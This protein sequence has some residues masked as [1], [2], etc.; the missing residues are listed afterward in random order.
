MDDIFLYIFLS[1]SSLLLAVIFLLR[2]RRNLPPS[3][4]FSL[5]LIGHLYLIKHPVHRSFQKL[6]QKYGHTFSLRFGSRLVVVISSPSAVQECFTKN[7]IVL[8]NRPLLISGKYLEYNHTTMALSPYGE[9]WRH[10][11]RISTLE[12][13]SSKRLNM[14]SAIRRDEVNRLLRKILLSGNEFYRV[15][16]DSM[17]LDLTSNIL[18]RMVAGKKYSGNNEADDGQGRRF[19]EIV[20]EILANGG[21]TNPG[22]FIPIWNW[23]DPSGFK[24]RIKKLGEKSDSLLQGLVDEIRNRKGGGDSMIHHLLHLQLTQ[25]GNYSDQIIKGLVQVS[26]NFLV[27]FRFVTIKHM[28]L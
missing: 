4:P 20:T 2:P 13:F 7:D 21:A 14:F 6:S 18:I 1:L 28:N 5:P 22:D 24:K 17:F 10:L 8:A 9:H 27:N 26:Q 25:P 12:V 3:P 19:R 15:E 11:R 16:F 23:I